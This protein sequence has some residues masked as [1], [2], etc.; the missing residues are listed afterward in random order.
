MI[1]EDHYFYSFGLF[2]LLIELRKGKVR[3]ELLFHKRNQEGTTLTMSNPFDQFAVDLQAALPPSSGGPPTSNGGPADAGNP[4]AS[5][6]SDAPSSVGGGPQATKPVM[7]VPHMAMNGGGPPPMGQNG[8][9]Y[10]GGYDGG[11]GGGGYGG[12]CPI[13]VL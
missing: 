6:F 3:L 2:L 1:C 13:I 12:G 7:N 11:Y 4:F 10:G 8:G 9:G 5:V